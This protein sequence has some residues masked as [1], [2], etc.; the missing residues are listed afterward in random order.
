M[1]QPRLVLASRSPQREVILSRLE[2]EFRGRAVR[3][4]GVRRGGPESVVIG[5]SLRK[6]RA[7]SDRL[8]IRKRSSIGG[9]T[10]IV[11]QGD[12]IGKP[13]DAEEAAEFMRRLSGSE[14]EVLGGLAV[15][16]FGGEERTAATATKVRFRALSEALIASYVATGRVG[17]PLR[18][19][20]HPAG[21]IDPGRVASPATT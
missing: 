5:N 12:V 21:R 7:V 15:V 10:V 4:R 20:R 18:R 14:H 8:A 1:A 6:A 13:A 2:L 17:A 11:H 16:R 19:L 9:D 3:R